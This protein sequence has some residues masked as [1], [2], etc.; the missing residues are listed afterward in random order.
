MMMKA[1]TL[2]E[3]AAYL[4]NRDHF[5]I[6][7]HRRPDG[8]TVGCA[9]ALCRGLRTLG[10]DAYLF[11]NPQFTPKLRPYVD[12]LTAETLPQN[13]TIVTVDIAAKGLLPFGAEELT[14]L[15]DVVIDHHGSP[16]D[17]GKVGFVEPQRAACGEIILDLLLAMGVTP[18]KE[19]AE[20]LYVAIS[21]DT[22]CFRYSN[23]TANT[24]RAGAACKE[25]GADTF[26][27]NHVF[28]MTKRP[29]RLKL[30]AHLVNTTEFYHQGQVAISTIPPTLI[31][32]LGLTQ[33]DIDDISG[34]GRK[35]EGVEISVMIRQEPDGGKLSVRTSPNYDAAAICTPLGGGGHRA[36]AGATIPGG[37]EEAK[38]GIL[39]VLA[40]M[41]LI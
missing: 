35:I 19:I 12:H 34:F 40:E 4:Q 23:T 16:K 1:L 18:T 11:P 32:D 28:F 8:D 29:A 33:D 9:A 24:L 30:E 37:I 14:D 39:A 22:G 17:F 41:G 6:L 31:Q 25:W 10:K 3:T 36:A 27:I 13:P 21:T 38:A 26:A 5:V 2:N 15:V 7:T 20:A